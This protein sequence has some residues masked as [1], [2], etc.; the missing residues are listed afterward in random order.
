MSNSS[1]ETRPG[2]EPC[3]SSPNIRRASPYEQR[4]GDT[5]LLAGKYDVPRDELVYCS[6]Q[7][8]GCR[9]R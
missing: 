4:N 7:L 6:E 3:R 8:G 2:T 9:E 5:L 1:R